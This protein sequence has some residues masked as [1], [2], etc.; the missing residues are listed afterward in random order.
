MG[1]LPRPEAER[2]YLDSLRWRSQDLNIRLA[3]LVVQIASLTR[4]EA[5][6]KQQL[7]AVEQLLTADGG[8][9]EIKQNDHVQNDEVDPSAA[10]LV[11]KSDLGQSVDF[12]A[13]GPKARA[14]YVAAANAIVEAAVPLHYRALAE[15]IQ[16][17]VT[18]SGVD[19]GATLI[20]HLHR[21]QHIFPRVG[22]G[23][24][25]LQGKVP[26][27]AAEPQLSPAASRR[28]KVRRRTR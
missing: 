4:E 2:I 9:S 16:K 12:S 7:R 11:T 3:A 27:I 26:V 25:G 8:L 13:W 24:Y 20:A 19:P 18:L 14:I 10:H 22:R 5:D 23:I 1:A 21:A 6:L 28:H 15:E 17:T